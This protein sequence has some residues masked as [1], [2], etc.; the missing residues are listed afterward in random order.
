MRNKKKKAVPDIQD[1]RDKKRERVN[2][3]WH[4]TC[5]GGTGERKLKSLKEE[6]LLL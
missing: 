2:A 1:G 6:A 5:L 3:G 4:K